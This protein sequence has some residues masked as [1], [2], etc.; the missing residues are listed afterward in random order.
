MKHPV[1]FILEHYPSLAS[2]IETQ[3]SNENE[4]CL[5]CNRLIHDTPLNKVV[6]AS[7]YGQKEAHC[8]ACQVFYQANI[9]AFGIEAYRGRDSLF[10]SEADLPTALEL[11]KGENPETALKQAGIKTVKKAKAPHIQECLV[12][13]EGNIVEAKLGMLPGCFLVITPKN[14]TLYAPGK[15]FAKLNS[16]KSKPF[17]VIQGSE[18]MAV[19]NAMANLTQDDFP[20]L[21]ISLSKKK[22]DLIQNLAFTTSSKNI[23]ICSDSGV[24]TLRSRSVQAFYEWFDTELAQSLKK[25][26]V[27]DLLG[28][29]KAFFKGNRTYEQV[30]EALNKADG[31]TRW[32][33]TMPD[34]PHEKIAIISFIERSLKAKVEDEVED[35]V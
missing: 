17:D 9:D 13:K 5:V 15:Y 7:V 24:L 21:L 16:A 22:A 26:V 10:C 28:T 31:I 11:A 35:E 14:G 1:D 25:K 34:C 27:L 23:N 18:L 8:V 3:E 6:F 2:G 30:L 20:C 19:K 32:V 12:L 4:I 33:S 29:M